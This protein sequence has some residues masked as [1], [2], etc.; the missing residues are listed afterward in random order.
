M[1]I[2]PTRLLSAL[3]RPF[4]RR[5]PRTYLARRLVQ[6]A[7]AATCILIG[8]QFTLFVRAA[9]RGDLPLPVRP[10]G[11]E[12]FLPISGLMGLV[13][14]VHQGRLNTIHPA[15]SI[16]VLV[17]IA[18]AFLLRK[19]FCSWI[20]PIGFLSEMLAAAGRRLFGRNFRFYGPVDFVLRGLKYLLMGFF[21]WSIFTMHPLQLRAFLESPYN[22]V[23][24]IKLGLFFVQA[25]QVTLIVLAV[26]ALG[27]LFVNG[28]WCRYLCPYG[29]L[30]GVFSRFSPTAIVRR[31]DLCTGCHGCD[32][33]CMARLPVSEAGVLRSFECT[34]CLDC[35][36][37][38]PV[39]D[40][41]EMETAGH[42]IRPAAFALAVLLLFLGG[43]VSARVTGHWRN[44]IED[45]E[46][47]RRIGELETY[48]HPGTGGPIDPAR[49]PRHPVNG[50]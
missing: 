1:Q 25:G 23:A 19:A 16:L 32:K 40:C 38:C 13:D 2:S 41:L 6:G 21:A 3:E 7:I 35:V 29:A 10:P 30:L 26:L 24:D 48:G 20:C 49:S 9:Q 45:H 39:D 37:A 44:G 15:A 50:R 18:L 28:L 36:A 33:A 31:A 22:R 43:V 17:A 12:G 14:A 5:R 27:S 47:V 8:W 11:V 42:R 46:Y 4:G 34:G